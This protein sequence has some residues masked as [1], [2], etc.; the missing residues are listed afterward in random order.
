PNSVQTINNDGDNIIKVYL[1]SPKKDFVEY[2]LQRVTVLNET[3]ARVILFTKKYT[4]PKTDADKQKILSDVDA[5]SKI[6]DDAILGV[7]FE[8]K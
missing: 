7:N 4:Y 1:V 8:I 6:W 3:T 2:N 5:N